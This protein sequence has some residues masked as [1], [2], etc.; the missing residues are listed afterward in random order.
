MTP[1][2]VQSAYQ[3]ALALIILALT[4]AIATASSPRVETVENR[5]VGA[6]G[7]SAE[8][9]KATPDFGLVS[10]QE[11]T[12]GQELSLSSDRSPPTD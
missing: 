4:L 9:A 7:R 3:W 10:L 11:C 2:S 6:N 5:G 12:P 8:A 1:R